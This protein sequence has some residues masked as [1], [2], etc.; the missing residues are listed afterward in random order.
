MGKSQY[1]HYREGHPYIVYFA[2]IFKNWVH[3][4]F[5]L[6]HRQQ[7]TGAPCYPWWEWTPRLLWKWWHED[8]SWVSHFHQL[9][10]QPTQ[11]SEEALSVSA[12][13]LCSFNPDQLHTNTDPF[14]QVNFLF[15]SVIFQRRKSND[16]EINPSNNE[17]YILTSICL[18]YKQLRKQATKR[19]TLLIG[20]LFLLD[21][22]DF[23]GI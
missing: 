13:S 20:S 14:A 11:C 17:K 5:C 10:S 21:R 19:L 16:L 4:E 1:L 8:A 15:H 18:H 3:R 23:N 6:Q 12:V 7:C 9:L 22:W 2:F